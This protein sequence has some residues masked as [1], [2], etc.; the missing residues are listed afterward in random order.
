ARIPSGISWFAANELYV[1]Y[2]DELGSTTLDGESDYVLHNLGLCLHI[3]DNQALRGSFSYTIRLPCWQDIQGGQRLD[4][5]VR[6]I[7][8]NGSRGNPALEP[9]KSQNFDLS[10]E[11]YY[12]EAS[13][14][15]A[16]Y[17]RKNVENFISSTVLR[18]SP[19]ELH[20]PVGGAY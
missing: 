9:L 3:C 13:Y 7:G 5:I 8:G 17:F 12:G 4:N 1:Q 6:T 20:T 19:F 16:G 11:W 10:L 14:V 2:A 15:S 18:E